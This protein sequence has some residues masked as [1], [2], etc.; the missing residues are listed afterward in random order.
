MWRRQ[1]LFGRLFALYL[2]SYGVFRFLAE[3]LRET[4]KAY[5]DLS[6]YQIM[7][8]M[9]I[10]AGGVALVARTLHQ[11]ASWERWR[12]AARGAS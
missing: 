7:S 5:G 10:V 12:L 11:P 1:I 8:L 6:A 4:T 2:A 3:F 9:M